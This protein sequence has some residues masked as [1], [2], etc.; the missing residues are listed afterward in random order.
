MNIPEILREKVLAA[1]EALEVALPD[2]RRIQVTKAADLRFGDF[3][4]NA[5]MML[6]K[7]AG[8]NPREFAAEL[9]EK[10]SADDL[11]EISIAGPGFLNFTLKPETWA[12]LARTQWAAG[13]LAI[14]Q[15]ENPQT[16]V[17][18][19]SA[20]NVAKPMHIGH[21]RSTIIGECLSRV[22]TK[23]GHKVIKD[24]HIGDWGTQFGMVT[25]A[26]KKGVN[27]E[28]LLEEP[29][30]ELLRLY[31]MASDAS[32]KDEAIKEACRAELVKLQQGDP[33]NTGIWKRCVELSRTGLENI[34]DRLDVRFDHWLGESDYNDA[35]APLVDKLTA[36]GL[37]RESKGAMCVFSSE[38]AKPKNDPFKVN[39]D[40]E[41][42]DFPMM[43]RKND[44]AFNYATT[45]IATV[46]FRVNEW[47]ADQ[48]WYVVDVRQSGHFAQLIEVSDRLGYNDINLVHVAFGTILG[49]D[50]TPLKTRAGDLPQLEDVL[51][52][53]VKA[54]QIVVDEKSHLD[55]EEEKAELAELIGVSSIK[56]TE[57]SHHRMSDYVF[58]LDKMVSLEGDTAP[59]LLYSY[60]R[61]RSIF[62]KL[63]AEVEL[64]G[65]NLALTEKAEIH[66]VRMLSRYSDQ[67][68]Q[69]LEDYRP[70][71]L[72]NYL[73]ELA[74]AFHSFFEA[75][76][77]LK[78]EGQTRES[79]LILCDL[80]SRVLKD[81]LALL[82][83][84]V[85]ERM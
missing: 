51:N 72:A 16:I 2:P 71:L 8:K 53:A 65:D 74:R 75:C 77:V 55:T 20:P 76:P 23:V 80:T 40:G 4:S 21:I 79:R 47:Q 67:V 19:F 15:V 63:D 60:V 1:L 33:E 6:A 3:Q 52:D 83:I 64:D 49:K 25:W 62:R 82:A 39:R 29:L 61:T 9:M 32:K 17:V 14:V 58:D 13:D 81:G 27:E 30:Q 41:W 44:G 68:H 28:L 46:E 56:F 34:Y 35:L 10:I 22:A 36:D 73:L 69:V 11:C 59:Y 78:S 42:Q 31:R 43:V 48:A 57:L 26:W 84:P 7:P 85:P 50:G 24:N 45:D 38:T 54:A 12:S 18:D 66:L 37:A 5:A 70:N